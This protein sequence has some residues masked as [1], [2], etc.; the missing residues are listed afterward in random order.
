M[1][2]LFKSAGVLVAAAVAVVAA[3]LPATAATGSPLSPDNACSNPILAQNATGWAV[4]FGGNGSRVAVADHSAAKFAF[5]VTTTSSVSIMTLP[6]VAVAAGQKW[7]FAADSQV[8]GGGRVTLAVDFYSATS[9]RLAHVT[10]SATNAGT[11]WTRATLATT[12]PATAARAVV[13][14]TATLT[15]GARWSSTACDYARAT[16]TPP[17]TTTTTPPPTTTTTTTTPPPTTATTTTTTTTTTAT[18]T[19]TT[20]TTTTVPPTTTTPPPPPSPGDG[21]QAA[22]VLGWGTPVDGDEFTGTALDTSRWGVYDGPGHNG[23][24]KRRPS[25]IAVANGVMT[26]SG[27]ADGTTGGMEFKRDRLYGRW[28]TRMQVPPGD[29]RYHP[30]LILWPEA[31]DWPVGGEVD[32]AE[33]AAGSSTVDFFLH[34]SASNK[35]TMASKTLDITQWH[36]YA[37]EWTST[38]IRGYIDGALWFTDTNPA[39]LPPR[40]MHQTIQLDW[41]PSGATSTRPS[42]MNVAWMRYYSL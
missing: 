27:T 8:T 29:S 25:Q 23:N 32:Y 35:Q 22:T 11:A 20:T 39:H 13:S 2:A 1:N 5:Q 6:A 21:T 14:Q 7:T 17:T 34:Y 3:A 36:N 9:R 33:T 30:V 18:T 38:G 42:A 40:S 19:A 12:A 28:E 10:G 37:V 31:E 41:F 24:G 26:M 16:T 15:R 4:S